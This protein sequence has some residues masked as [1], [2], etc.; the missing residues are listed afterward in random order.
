MF[1]DDRNDRYG[2]PT[3]TNY[4]LIVENLSSRVSWQVRNN[5]DVNLYYL[6][7]IFFRFVS[8]C[9][10]KLIFVLPFV[11]FGDLSYLFECLLNFFS[12]MVC[13]C[14]VLIN[15]Q[16]IILSEERACNSIKV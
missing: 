4:R 1:R 10:F 15:V 7:T 11:N 13:F 6:I 12:H 9:Y 2:P 5:L 8:I 3:R 14:E 16:S